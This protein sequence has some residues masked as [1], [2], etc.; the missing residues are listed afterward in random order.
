MSV[1]VKETPLYDA[2]L[3]VA[4]PKS[5]AMLAA[6]Q[7]RWSK[8]KIQRDKAEDG[9]RGPEEGGAELTRGDK[10]GFFNSDNIGMAKSSRVSMEDPDG[11]T[12]HNL[13][14]KRDLFAS[15]EEN[16]GG[17]VDNRKERWEV[18]VFRGRRGE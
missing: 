4:P 13:L 18:A 15:R 3:S 7:E 2:K 1:L 16:L 5:L 6:E 9:G 14:E 10:P 12:H 17:D 8:T 11:T